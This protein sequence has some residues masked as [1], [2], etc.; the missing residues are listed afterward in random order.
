MANLIIKSSANDLVIQGSDESPAITVAAAGTTTFAEATTLSGATTCSTTLGVTGNTTLSGTANA[1]G[2]VTAGTLGSSV[3]FP[4]TIFN[5]PPA[6][7]SLYTSA[8][9]S[10]SA[11]L[12]M[13]NWNSGTGATTATNITHQSTY[14]SKGGFRVTNAGTYEVTFSAM[15][16][17]TAAGATYTNIYEFW[18]N[19]SATRLDIYN[20]TRQGLHAHQS[21]SEQFVLSAGDNVNVK[22]TS[23]TGYTYANDYNNFT[24]HRIG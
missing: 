23:G 17:N 1:L 19:N 8:A 12:D 15:S 4:S 5:F 7:G 11:M 9:T 21:G 24:I 22:Q 6:Y 16:N 18:I 10:G 14:S 3:V 2:T 13:N 20:Q